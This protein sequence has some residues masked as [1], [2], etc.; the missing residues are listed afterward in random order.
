MVSKPVVSRETSLKKSKKRQAIL[1][2]S[3]KRA[4]V[5]WF[6]NIFP[7]GGVFDVL[8]FM[9]M[10]SYFNPCAPETVNFAADV[11]KKVKKT[12]HD[13]PT[14]KKACDSIA[15]WAF[16]SGPAAPWRFQGYAVI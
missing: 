14:F 13:N 4:T 5:Q 1:P 9:L 2:F 12:S 7:L 15:V 6:C 8:D 11:P 16:F 3:K 10:L